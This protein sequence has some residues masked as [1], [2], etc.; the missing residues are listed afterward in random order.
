MSSH[1]TNPTMSDSPVT[2][3]DLDEL[4]QSVLW[5]E[6]D[7]AALQRAADI[8]GPQTEAIMDVWYGFVGSHPHLVK[9]FAGADGHPDAAYL[10]GVR[11]RFGQWIVD[12]CRSDHGAGWLARQEEI[13][14]RH[15]TSKKN[16]TDG[17]RSPSAHVPLRQVI[18]LIVPITVTIRPF[19]ERGDADADQVEAMYQAW[20]KAV[21]LSVSLWARPY[22]PTV[23]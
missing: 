7:A 12:V 5:T 3:T 21:V 2:A 14:L 19:L 6:A 10:A 11:E 23:W 1:P 22:C 16:V 17:V 20:F 15:H 4:Q 13:G 8:L 18:A 9:E